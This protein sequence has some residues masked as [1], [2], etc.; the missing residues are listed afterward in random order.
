MVSSRRHENER[1]V[2]VASVAFWGG[3]SSMGMAESRGLEPFM[4]CRS[5][6]FVERKDVAFVQSSETNGA[7]EMKS[8]MQ[9][10]NGLLCCMSMH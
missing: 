4:E 10:S 3:L 8:R 1:H 7:V 2:E 6:P 9:R 5:L